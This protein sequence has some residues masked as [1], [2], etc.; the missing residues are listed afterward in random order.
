[1]LRDIAGETYSLEYDEEDGFTYA[2]V[3]GSGDLLSGAGQPAVAQE[4]FPFDVN[5][6]VA[7]ANALSELATLE[8]GSA[9]Y[10]ALLAGLN[11]ANMLGA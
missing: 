8:P 5:D 11:A 2:P 3:S 6:P 10:N 4:P 1:M 9:E 7:A